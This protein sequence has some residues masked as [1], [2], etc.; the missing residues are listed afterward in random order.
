[1]KQNLLKSLLI[2]IFIFGCVSVVGMSNDAAQQAKIAK[3]KQLEDEAAAKVKAKQKPEQ[4]V[5]LDQ[6]KKAPTPPAKPSDLNLPAELK[7][8]PGKPLP[9]TPTKKTDTSKALVPYKQSTDVVPYKK[10][11]TDVVPYKK[12]STDLVPSASKEIGK[13]TKTDS[14]KKDTTALDVAKKV[15][16]GSPIL[17]KIIENKK[18]IIGGL[19]IG[20]AM[21]IGLLALGGIGAGVGVGL[22]GSKEDKKEG[23]N[24]TST[25]EYTRTEDSVV[26]PNPYTEPTPDNQTYQSKL[27][28]IADTFKNAQK[29]LEASLEEGDYYSPTFSISLG[30]VTLDKTINVSIEY[31]FQESEAGI[32]GSP[33]TP[34]EISIVPNEIDGLAIT[35]DGLLA[36]VKPDY[37]D[38]ATVLLKPNAAF[39]FAVKIILLIKSVQKNTSFKDDSEC[40]REILTQ[41]SLLTSRL[42]LVD[43]YA[44]PSS[45]TIMSSLPPSFQDYIGK[46]TT[47]I[48]PE[49]LTAAQSSTQNSF[50][51]GET[52]FGIRADISDYKERVTAMND[53]VL[54]LIQKGLPYTDQKLIIHSLVRQA[55]DLG[56]KLPSTNAQA[57]IT[58]RLKVIIPLLTS[59]IQSMTDTTETTDDTT[60]ATTST[61][62]TNS[63]TTEQTGFDKNDIATVQSALDILN[64]INEGSKSMADL[65]SKPRLG[66]PK[67][68]LQ[69]IDLPSA[70]DIYFD[71]FATIQNKKFKG[72]NE[73]KPS[74]LLL[75]NNETVDVILGVLLRGVTNVIEA[76]KTISESEQS[77]ELRKNGST[78]TINPTD[79]FNKI[80]KDPSELVSKA[81]ED[82]SNAAESLKANPTDDTLKNAYV[83]AK[84]KF[85]DAAKSLS[86][87]LQTYRA[88]FP[89]YLS[90]KAEDG[91][92]RT[93]AE[94]VID[95]LKTV[96]TIGQQD[97]LTTFDKIYAKFQK[98]LGLP[99]G[100]IW[101]ATT[102]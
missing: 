79:E 14:T 98:S 78:F 36:Q 26:T 81:H 11:T 41:A 28:E 95:T 39:I 50:S 86:V 100:D 15:T 18:K 19:A 77:V 56:D 17:T 75:G 47:K 54:P 31:N 1:M 4:P 35:P 90:I 85:D 69:D 64:A 60:K 52:I 2:G 72:D 89:P 68:D 92:S 57:E 99:I 38:I 94:F 40:V 12:P 61:A 66:E 58:E 48:Y 5:I 53:T 49:M 63:A 34:I 3:A 20:G 22:L 71:N 29:C 91:T 65:T 32:I 9:A 74:D 23:D 10:T 13:A 67:S 25:G 102:K 93:T 76:E 70:L 21:L 27:S 45:Q 44:T 88:N 8:T 97:A 96:K 59:A 101:E 43:E 42:V 51:I 16:A 7:T 6:A 33:L 73:Y 24:I 87:A 80:M 37:Q 30:Q 46:I 62:T 84:K 55:S 83:D 82:F